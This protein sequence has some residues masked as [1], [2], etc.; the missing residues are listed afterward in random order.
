MKRI[1]SE[2]ATLQSNLQQ[3][4]MQTSFRFHNDDIFFKITYQIKETF[5]LISIWQF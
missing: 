4:L 2:T 3:A 5:Q 1:H